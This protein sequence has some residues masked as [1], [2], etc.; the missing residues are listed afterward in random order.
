[1]IFYDW[2]KMCIEVRIHAL[3]KQGIS[4]VYSFSLRDKNKHIHRLTIDKT[5]RTYLKAE[6][7]ISK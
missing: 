4:Q 1:M 6:A 5:R 2:S 7:I 3:R